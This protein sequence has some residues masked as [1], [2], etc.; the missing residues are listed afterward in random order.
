ME[1]LS[2]HSQNSFCQV[3]DNDDQIVQS[4][5]E[6]SIAQKWDSTAKRRRPTKSRESSAED[7]P[8]EEKEFDNPEVLSQ[9]LIRV[10]HEDEPPEANS[11]GDRHGG[12]MNS[13][14][15][16]HSKRG[17]G[18]SRRRKSPARS[19]A[20]VNK[21]LYIQDVTPSTNRRDLQP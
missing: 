19:P 3:Y 7:L 15:P 16:S 12:S 17:G 9:Q 6:N 11:K 8:H 14:A 18:S 5:G 13:R 21:T 4:I 2:Q 20:S 1:K 10:V